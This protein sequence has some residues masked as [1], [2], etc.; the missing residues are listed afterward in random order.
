MKI[1]DKIYEANINRILKSIIIGSVP[2]GLIL[3]VYIIGI[4]NRKIGL[5]LILSTLF[6]IFS[7]ILGDLL[8]YRIEIDRKNKKEV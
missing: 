7:C 1:I 8:L 3:I 2:I 4:S 6:I 5:V